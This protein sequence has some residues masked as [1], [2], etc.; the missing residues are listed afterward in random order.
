MLSSLLMQAPAKPGACIRVI[1][2]GV[3][4]GNVPPLCT[5]GR[6]AEGDRGSLLS[7]STLID[8]ERIRKITTVKFVALTAIMP[9]AVLP[10]CKS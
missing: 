2:V 3:S 5:G 7:V 10:N 1:R 8:K 4:G 9:V 6:T